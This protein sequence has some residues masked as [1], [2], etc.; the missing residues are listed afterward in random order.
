M[1]KV[2]KETCKS[3]RHFTLDKLLYARH[4]QEGLG[5]CKFDVEERKTKSFFRSIKFCCDKYDAT[6]RR[7]AWIAFQNGVENG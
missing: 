7:K 6:D 1:K 5:H 2:A 4:A 3:C